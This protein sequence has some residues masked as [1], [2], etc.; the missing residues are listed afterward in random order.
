MYQ[1]TSLSQQYLDIR[2][3]FLVQMHDHNFNP[4]APTNNIIQVRTRIARKLLESVIT[5]I[6][7][8]QTLNLTT[9]EGFHKAVANLPSK[10]LYSIL[11]LEA[12]GRNYTKEVIDFFNTIGTSPVAN[13]IMLSAQ[14]PKY[15]IILFK[16][17]PIF[18]HVFIITSENF[19]SGKGT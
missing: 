2:F 12:Y 11:D 7:E 3:E 9:R 5:Y 4:Y 6:N 13:I 1:W 17:E 10:K 15:G 8:K 14:L 19:I 16:K 18:K